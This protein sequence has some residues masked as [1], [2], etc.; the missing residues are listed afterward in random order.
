LNP[1][2]GADEP[3]AIELRE[4]DGDERR[5]AA[6]R[7]DQPVARLGFGARE[8]FAGA[9]GVTGYVG[10]YESSD[11]E[12]GTRLLAA[13]AERLLAEGARRVVGPLDGSTWH[14]YRVVMPRDQE[15]EDGEPFLSEPRNPPGWSRQFEDAGFRPQLE[16]ETRLVRRPESDPD[17]SA[18]RAA[19][20]ERGV[21]VRPLDLANYERELRALY[22][23]SVAAFA[24]N[25]FYTPID[26]EEFAK[27][28]AGLRPL[29]DP[30]LVRLAESREGRLLGYVFAFPDA[31]APPARPRIV[32]KT[33]AVH[34]EARGFG[35]GGILVDDIHAIA[36]KRGAAV[37]HALMQV[38]NVSETISRRSGSE[39]LRRYVLYGRER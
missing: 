25:P 3:M 1:F 30:T 9:P 4:Q 16:Y 8:G 21:R 18:R 28:Y 23:L 5:M 19:L 38:S 15:I 6:Y 36:A 20:A 17:L 12:A 2:L 33:L 11:A 35:L 13:A 32:L 27:L 34:H 10:W 7:D 14:R 26:F 31:L 39:R 37:L 22:A 29:L 24:A